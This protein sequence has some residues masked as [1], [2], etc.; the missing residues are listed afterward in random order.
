MLLGF[1]NQ[2][3]LIKEKKNWVISSILK[4]N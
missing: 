2:L 1:Q 4:I 3:V